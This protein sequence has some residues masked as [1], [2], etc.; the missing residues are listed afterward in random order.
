M[1]TDQTPCPADVPSAEN[2]CSAGSPA[3]APAPPLSLAEAMVELT[4]AIDR[5]CH[6]LGQIV[7]QNADLIALLTNEEPEDE[8][9]TD[10]LGRVIG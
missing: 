9:P 4:A 1:E 5:Q 6:L 3:P 10:L 2:G 8:Q 7:A